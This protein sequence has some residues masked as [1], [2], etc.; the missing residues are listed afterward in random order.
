MSKRDYY[1]ILGVSKGTSK[2]EIKD[3]YRKLALQYHPD[4]NKSPEAEEKFKEISEAYAVLSDEEKR[5]QYDQFGHAGIG[6]RYTTEDIFRGADFGDIFRD[7]GF[8]FGGFESIFERFFGGFGPRERSTRG[9]DLRYDLD[10]TLE[11]VVSG[12]TK[13][14]EVP[15]T[16]H[17][18]VCAGSGA[19]P[20]SSPRVCPVCKGQGQV[21]RVQSSGFARL[22]R[23]ETCAKCRGEGQIIEKPCRNCHGTGSVEVKRRLSVKVPLGVDEGF[24]LRLRG[25]GDHGPKDTAPGDLYL[26]VHVRPH[27]FFQRDGDDVICEVPV[28][29]AQAALGA[30]ILV[31]TLESKA[32]LRI[33]V[34][35]QTGTVFRMRGK[36]VPRLN[37]FGRGDE[38]VRVIVRTPTNLTRRQ[39]DLLEEFAKE[40]GTTQNSA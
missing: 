3:S 20:G 35:T 7:L 21:Q 17:C 5:V 18:N 24:S 32:E 38:M 4:R 2:D 14:I 9:A 1:D 27:Q 30:Q 19:Q 12:L 37:S 22:V 39:R 31:P 29:F 10:L 28:S 36:G 34:G 25:E 13:E 16:Q 6:A 23:I 33:P 11:Q 40:S 8:G 15:R 26:V